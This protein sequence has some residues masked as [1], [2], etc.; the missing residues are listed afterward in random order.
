M[1]SRGTARLARAF[2]DLTPPT[3]GIRAKPSGFASRNATAARVTM[4]YRVYSGPKG[5]A[6][7]SPMNKAQALFKQ[8]DALDEALAWARHVGQ[9]GR[10]ALLLE[11]DDGT[12]MDRREIGAA[13]GAGQRE[14][15]SNPTH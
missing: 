3:T 4:S 13:I 12:R 8:F 6:D 7:I 5:S 11:G 2:F 14:Q 10:V 15:V 1:H 9:S